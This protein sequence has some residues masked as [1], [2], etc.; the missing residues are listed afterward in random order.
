MTARRLRVAALAV[1]AVVAGAGWGVAPVASASAVGGASVAPVDVLVS[2]DGV[3]FAPALEGGLFDGLGVLAP[4]GAVTATLWIRNPTAA[5]A[6]LRVSA[7]NVRMS[8]GEFA[9]DVTMMVW[10]SGSAQTRASTLEDVAACGIVV[11]EQTVAAGATVA[12]TVTFV[13]ADGQSASQGETAELDLLVAMRE[14]GTTTYPASA[15]NDD[16]TLVPGA[17]GPGASALASGGAEG[18]AL[19]WP[20]GGVLLGLGVFLSAAR[21][22][23]ADAT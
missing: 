14:A 1:V 4:A 11:P 20:I 15:C 13:M 21:L 17:S 7:R 23:R 6:E 19:L 3:H 16:G 22:R 9:E 10:N 12:M 5:A 8:S 18:V 2:A